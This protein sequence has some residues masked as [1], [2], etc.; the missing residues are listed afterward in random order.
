MCFLSFSDTPTPD[1]F[2]FP[3]KGNVF[4]NN[5]CILVSESGFSGQCKLNYFIY[6]SGIGIV[7]LKQTFIL[8]SRHEFSGQ[9]KPTFFHFFPLVL[10]A[11]KNFFPPSVNLFLQRILYSWQRKLIIGLVETIL[12]QF[13]KY[14]FYQK[15]FF[16]LVKKCSK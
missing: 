9:W 16:H 6:F 2:I 7:F 12:F 1:S 11:V 8:A 10:L 5:S 15:Q 4:I 14:P 3:S 13:L